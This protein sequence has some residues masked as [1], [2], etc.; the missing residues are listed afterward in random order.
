M[1]FVKHTLLILFPL[2]YVGFQFAADAP[3]KG[4][5]LGLSIKGGIITVAGS[6]KP[7]SPTDS[8]Q[9]AATIP[10]PPAPPAPDQ[11]P[12]GNN[13]SAYTYQSTPPAG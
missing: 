3:K 10:E 12:P 8:V 7:L 5:T 6:D 13:Q 4:G 1:H 2:M 11:S 9:A